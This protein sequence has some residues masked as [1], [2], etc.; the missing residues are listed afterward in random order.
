LREAMGS[1]A[2]VA[3]EFHSILERCARGN[4]EKLRSREV[5]GK[6][7]GDGDDR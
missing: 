3:E 4:L 6:I 7:Q 2:S 5:R 1:L